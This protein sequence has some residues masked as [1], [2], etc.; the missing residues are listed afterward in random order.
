MLIDEPLLTNPPA[1]PVMSSAPT[2]DHGLAAVTF[3]WFRVALPPARLEIPAA[4][5]APVLKRDQSYPI[6][7]RGPCP[8]PLY[9]AL[10]MLIP[11]PSLAAPRAIVPW[12]HAWISEWLTPETVV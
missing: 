9:H 11:P 12:Y 4:G 7:A 10:L 2:F 3:T 1:S 8:A 5:R 6:V